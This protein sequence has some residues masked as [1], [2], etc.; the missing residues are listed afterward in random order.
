MRLMSDPGQPIRCEVLRE[1]VLP[2]ELSFLD[3]LGDRD[4]GEHLVHRAQ[5]NFVSIRTGTAVALVRLADGGPVENLAV[6][7][8]QDGARE[9][10]AR[11]E[12]LHVSPRSVTAFSSVIR[13]LRRQIAGRPRRDEVE[14]GDA[15]R[16]LRLDLDDEGLPGAREPVRDDDDGPSGPPPSGYVRTPWRSNL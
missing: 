2:G 10:V 6:P 14:A 8:Q 12:P 4:G 11:G 9:D 16:R 1:R 7:R 5:L 3:E 15:M 13:R